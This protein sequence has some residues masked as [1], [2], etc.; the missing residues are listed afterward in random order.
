MQDDRSGLFKGRLQLKSIPLEMLPGGRRHDNVRRHT[1]F[2]RCTNGHTVLG[3]LC[4]E[5]LRTEGL[6]IGNPGDPEWFAHGTKW[7]NANN[8]LRV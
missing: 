2:F 6:T 8:V 5:S 4:P 3:I 7:K 1:Y